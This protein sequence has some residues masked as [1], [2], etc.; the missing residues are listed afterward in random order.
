[1]RNFAD[2]AG[3]FRRR[4]ARAN[5]SSYNVHKASRTSYHDKKG[6][7]HVMETKA[8]PTSTRAHQYTLPVPR[9]EAR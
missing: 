1:M 9:C 5:W 3:L 4:P 8:N 2:P 6:S 7:C